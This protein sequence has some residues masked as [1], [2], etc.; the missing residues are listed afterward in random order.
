MPFSVPLPFPSRWS[1]AFVGG[2]GGGGHAHS[3][4]EEEEEEE[5]GSEIQLPTN[6][7]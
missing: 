1:P 2:G 7:N 4:E 5:E 3:E 6:E